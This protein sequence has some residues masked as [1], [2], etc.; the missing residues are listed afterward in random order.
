MGHLLSRYSISYEWLQNLVMDHNQSTIWTTNDPFF[1]EPNVI[2]QNLRCSSFSNIPVIL[3]IL[4]HT[5]YQFCWKTLV[6]TV[7]ILA[8]IKVHLYPKGWVPCHAKQWPTPTSLAIEQLA[9]PSVL[10]W[11]REP[12][13]KLCLHVTLRAHLKMLV[14][15][16]CYCQVIYNDRSFLVNITG[17]GIPTGFVQ[18]LPWVREFVPVPAILP[19]PSFLCVSWLHMELDVGWGWEGR[20][21]YG[22]CCMCATI[23]TIDKYSQVW[24]WKEV[25]GVV[26][27][28]LDDVVVICKLP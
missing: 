27:I 23:V 24:S 18:V 10:V 25:S 15:G 4:F 12:G 2:P 16:C 1:L 21:G 11:I 28:V 7:A 17:T 8:V 9:I 22:G 20:S 13:C 3:I 5:L 19:S 26:F 6:M 14:I